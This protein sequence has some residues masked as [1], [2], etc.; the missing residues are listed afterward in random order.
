MWSTRFP[1]MTAVG[2]T[3]EKLAD[4]YR[5]RKKGTSETLKWYYDDENRIFCSK[6]FLK[7]KK[8]V[9][10][11]RKMLFTIFKGTKHCV[12]PTNISQNR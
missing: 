7:H 1:A 4:V 6:P 2:A 10:I 11:R 9:C 5:R 12:F 8:V 3:L